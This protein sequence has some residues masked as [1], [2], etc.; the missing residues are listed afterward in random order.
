MKEEKR[1]Y[2]ELQIACD[3]FVFPSVCSIDWIDSL[4]SKEISSPKPKSHQIKYIEID[5]YGRD[6][7]SVSFFIVWLQTKTA[8]RNNWN[9]RKRTN[10]ASVHLATK[11]RL[12]LLLIA[13][14]G[15]MKNVMRLWLSREK[16]KTDLMKAVAMGV[17]VLSPIIMMC[18]HLKDE[19]K[20]AHSLSLSVFHK[21]EMLCWNEQN[22]FMTEGITLHWARREKKQTF[23]QMNG[24]R[25]VGTVLKC[26]LNRIAWQA[27]R[28]ETFCFLPKSE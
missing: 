25:A 7:A 18:S 9:R 14:N 23:Q 5:L 10:R 28:R 13:L 12:I 27:G 16:E 3:S 24:T 26:E 22:E 8:Q 17:I 1:N 4:Y 11:Q 20:P 2:G 6:C 15:S 21:E 19:Y